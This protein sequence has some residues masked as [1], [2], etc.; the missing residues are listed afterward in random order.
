[1]NGQFWAVRR[2]GW[3]AAGATVAIA[4]M[5]VWLLKAKSGGNTATVLALAVSVASLAVAFRGLRPSPPLSRVARDLANEVAKDRGRARRQALGMSGDFRPADVTYRSPLPQDEP[6]LLRWRSDGGPE[7]G[8]LESVADFYRSLDRGRM[9]ILGEPGAGKTV[10]ATQLVIDLVEGLPDGELQPGARPPV[11]VWLSLTS[12]DLGDT[13]SLARASAEQIAA[14]L[15]EQI[16]LQISVAYPIS[17]PA[18]E[19]LTRGRWL[20][21]VLDGLDEMDPPS[22]D[23]SHSGRPRA[24]AVVRALNSGTGRRP[25]VVVC[26]RGEYGQLA[27]SPDAIG[28]DP[29]LQDASQIVLQ[30]LDLPTIDNYLTRRFPGVSPGTVTSRWQNVLAALGATTTP[31]RGVSLADVLSS[32]WRLFLAAT[33]YQDQ[34]SDPDEL[35]RLPATDVGRYLIGQLIP[36]VTHRTPRPRGDHYRPPDVHTWLVTLARHLT[37][38]SN[39]PKLRWSPTDLRLERLWVIAGQKSVQRL[40]ALACCA[41]LGAAFGISGI[42]WAQSHRHWYPNSAAAWTGLI[43]VLGV[44]ALST[45]FSFSTADTPLNR[46]ELRFATPTSRKRLMGALA[47]GLATG[48]VYGVGIVAV[49]ALKG[50]LAIGKV[51]ALEYGLVLGVIV[52]LTNGLGR[53]SS[54]ASQPTSVMRQNITY[55]LTVGLGTW[56]VTSFVAFII[57]RNIYKNLA[58][59]SGGTAA[60]VEFVLA[61]GLGLAIWTGLVVGMASWI[62]YLIGCALARRKGELPPR[63]GQFFDWAYRAGLLRMSGTAV[64]FRHRELQAWLVLSG[65]ETAAPPSL[66]LNQ[67]SG[68]QQAAE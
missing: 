26:R 57:Y 36:A 40:A 4:A 58:V 53:N 51:G 43:A 37:Q 42:A 21:P 24:T 59:L 50:S 66:G 32:P 46:L 20:L 12:I 63:V 13:D 23:D 8:T 1:M 3:V 18:A 64:Q 67:T 34:G 5:T 25:V 52:G 49:T 56:F 2:P 65:E 39:D 68:V 19:G 62:R 55:A 29:V 11:P 10:L 22:P 7:H 44:V 33:A 16:A 31:E 61:L 6:D 47:G 38:T 27:R 41:L 17:K 15:D 48:V 14:R 60:T 45:V 9:V 54:V 35:I 28:E 30:P